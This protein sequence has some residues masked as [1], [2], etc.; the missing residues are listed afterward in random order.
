MTTLSRRLLTV[1][2]GVLKAWD[3]EKHDWEPQS[4]DFARAV[5]CSK[6]KHDGHTHKGVCGNRTEE[7]LR[8]RMASGF[9]VGDFSSE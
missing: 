2:D 3:D 9:A 4:H 6:T 1:G 5:S 8:P 7:Y